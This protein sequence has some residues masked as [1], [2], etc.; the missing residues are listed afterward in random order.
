MTVGAHSLNRARKGSEFYLSNEHQID[1]VFTKHPELL[2]FRNEKYKDPSLKQ[3]D[4]QPAKRPLHA[5]IKD[6]SG[7]EF[8]CKCFTF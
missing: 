8:G 6:R 3:L 4:K 5:S 2:E 1:P 7:N